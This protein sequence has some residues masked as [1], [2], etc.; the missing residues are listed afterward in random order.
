MTVAPASVGPRRD[1]GRDREPV[2]VRH[3]RVEQDELE[4]PARR[5]AAAVS[6]SMAARPLATAVGRHAPARDL[7]GENAPV[8]VVVVD[9]Q[10]V[11]MR[12]AAAPAGAGSGSVGDVER[13]GEM[14]RAAGAGVALD[15]DPSAHQ[16]HERGRDRQAEAGAAEPARRRSVGLTEGLEDR[17]RACPAECRC[18]C[19]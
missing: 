13:D 3:V 6:A 19:R 4:R 18:R 11:E 5:R 9:D 7:L 12:R 16:L 15:P 14:E 2:H 10:H 8:D 1:C 17:R